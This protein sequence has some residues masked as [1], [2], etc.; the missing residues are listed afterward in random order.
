MKN[1]C[2]FLHFLVGETNVCLIGDVVFLD[3]AVLQ[4]SC[5]ALGQ[6]GNG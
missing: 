4:V 1:D 3:G 5:D 2:V 6:G